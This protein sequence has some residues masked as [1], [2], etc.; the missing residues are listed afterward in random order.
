ME[1]CL[2]SLRQKSLAEFAPRKARIN[3][4]CFSGDMRGIVR[5]GLLHAAAALRRVGFVSAP[6]FFLSQSKHLL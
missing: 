2:F 1:Y 6:P 5:T 4:D 3:S